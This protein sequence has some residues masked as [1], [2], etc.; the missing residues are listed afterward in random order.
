MVPL[1]L[2]SAQV[3]T[4]V[5]GLC[6]KV[7]DVSALMDNALEELIVK[8]FIH[9]KSHLNQCNFKRMKLLSCRIKYLKALLFLNS[10]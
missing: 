1:V 9:K 10:F 7:L 4:F 5:N 2:V 3:Q 6:A 8:P